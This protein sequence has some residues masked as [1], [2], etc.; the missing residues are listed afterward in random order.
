[1]RADSLHQRGTPLVTKAVVAVHGHVAAIRAELTQV[2]NI[3][4]QRHARRLRDSVRIR[5]MIHRL[6]DVIQPLLVKAPLRQP[7]L[8]LPQKT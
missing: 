3:P 8:K 5:Q 2:L 7:S 4:V 1:M 6:D